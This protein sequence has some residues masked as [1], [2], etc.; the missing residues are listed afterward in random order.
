MIPSGIMYGWEEIQQCVKVI[1]MHCPKEKVAE[2]FISEYFIIL[3]QLN[4]EYTHIA[5]ADVVAGTFNGFATSEADNITKVAANG[6]VV[7]IALGLQ[8]PMYLS[9]GTWH[10][11]IFVYILIASVAPVWALLQS[12]DYL[13]SYL[14]I[15]M[16]VSAVIGVFVANP[17]CR[18]KS[19]CLVY[20]RGPIS[21]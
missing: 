20:V 1:Y 17:V 2:A 19:G 12:R 18:E 15:F 16:I 11:I 10:I 5:F 3:Y 14:L 13:N 4:I 7:A 6:A 8:F 21:L 9:L